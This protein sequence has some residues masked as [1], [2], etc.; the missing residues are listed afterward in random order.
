MH[1]HDGTGEPVKSSSSNTHGERTICSCRTSWHCIIQR[2]QRVQPCNRRGEHWLQHSRSAKFNSET[3]T[4]RQRSQLDSEDRE[5]PSATSTSKWSSTTSSI[6]PFQQSIAG[7]D[8]SRWKHW[9]MRD[10]WCWPKS[11]MQS[12]LGVLGRWH[13]LLHVRSL[14]TRWYSREQEVHQVR[15]KSTEKNVKH[16]RVLY[17][18]FN[19]MG[20]VHGYNVKCGDIHGK[21]FLNYSK[22]RQES[23]KVLPWNRCSMS[24]HNWWIT[25]TKSVAW[26]NS[27]WEEFLDTSVID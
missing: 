24:Q 23:W 2:G 6:Q 25:R 18:T 7:R 3:I 26:T 20:N 27:V 10:S 1:A 5:P 21:E 12:M 15:A 19:N 16:C 8:Q 22:C 4:R 14:L 17:R 9:T 11:T 13:R